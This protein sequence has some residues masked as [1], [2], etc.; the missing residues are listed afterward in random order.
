MAHEEIYQLTQRKNQLD[1]QNTQIQDLINFLQSNGIE[2]EGSLSSHHQNLLDD[3]VDQ[4]FNIIENESI[5]PDQ[6]FL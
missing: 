1:F 2:S 6:I 3:R 5:M 4:I